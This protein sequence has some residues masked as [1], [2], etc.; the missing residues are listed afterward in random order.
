MINIG[1]TDPNF[2]V[3]ESFI[4]NTSQGQ[5]TVFEAEPISLSIDANENVVIGN[6]TSQ[7]TVNLLVTTKT[8][9]QDILSRVRPASFRTVVEEDGELSLV[10]TFREDSALNCMPVLE[11]VFPA[12][13]EVNSIRPHKE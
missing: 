8:A 1:H 7:G 6:D 13:I 2:V 9:L 12:M 3:T 4:I 10:S 11:S 5:V